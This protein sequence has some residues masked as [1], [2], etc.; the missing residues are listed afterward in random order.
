MKR[1]KS[2]S[3]QVPSEP[4]KKATAIT[5]NVANIASTFEWQMYSTYEKILR[6]IAYMLRSMPKFACNWTKA[7]T[8]TDPAELEVAQPK[9][10]LLVKDES[11]YLERRGLQK[12]SPISNTSFIWPNGLLCAK[13]RTRQLEFVTFWTIYPVILD[14]LHPL[15]RLFLKHLHKGH[16]HHNVEFLRASTH[17]KFSILKLYG[18]SSWLVSHA[19]NEKRKRSHHFWLTSHEKD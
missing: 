3:D 11:L 18:L 4:E 1:N 13:R 12:S 14:A 6:F 19:A 15:V 9:L 5:A 17:Q 10:F 16:C 7:G 2:K 8:I